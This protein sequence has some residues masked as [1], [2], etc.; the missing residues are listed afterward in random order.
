LTIHLFSYLAGF[1]F[2]L[3]NIPYYLKEAIYSSSNRQA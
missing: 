2:H 1:V 3:E